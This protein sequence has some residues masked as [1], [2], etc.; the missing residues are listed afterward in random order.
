MP[1]A[2]TGRVGVPHGELRGPTYRQADGS[3]AGGSNGDTGLR[4]DL[5][6]RPLTDNEQQKLRTGL[7]S[8]K[9]FTLRRCQ[10][11]LAHAKGEVPARIATLVGCTRYTVRHV[12]KDFQ[13]RGIVCIQDEC[14]SVNARPR[15]RPR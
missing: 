12:I 4:T 3:A 7:R 1:P 14:T 9:A 10:I 8:S 11:L 15:G 5:P 6:Q 2:R 13:V